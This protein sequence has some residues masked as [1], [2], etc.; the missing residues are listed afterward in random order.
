MRSRGTYRT[1]LRVSFEKSLHL[2]SVQHRKLKVWTRVPVGASPRQVRVSQKA[3]ES[4]NLSSRG[5]NRSQ[6]A[7]LDFS[8]STRVSRESFVLYHCM[9]NTSRAITMGEW[10]IHLLWK[11][12]AC[13]QQFKA[14]VNGFDTVESVRWVINGGSTV[15]K[16]QECIAI[17]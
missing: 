3:P 14:I 2:R 15:S 6:S 17:E 12:V 16:W 8:V 7:R 9:N 4:I 11:A 5:K 1:R 10:F 13:R